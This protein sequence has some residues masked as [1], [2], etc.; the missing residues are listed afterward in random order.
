MQ[1]MEQTHI[2]MPQVMRGVVVEIA[3][4]NADAERVWEKCGY[5]PERAYR[6]R[7]V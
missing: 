7:F 2:R 3:Q 1:K 4:T 5:L 6:R